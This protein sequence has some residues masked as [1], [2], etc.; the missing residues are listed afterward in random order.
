MLKPRALRPGDRVAVVAPASPF[1]REDFDAG[2][3]ELRR[4][5]FDPAFDDCVFDRSGYVA[6]EPGVRARA[7]MDAWRDPLVGGIIGARGGYGSVHLLPL[8]DPAEL[9]RSPKVFVG[10]SDLTSILAFL[11]TGCG[12]ACFHGPSVAG[13]LGGGAGGYDAASLLAAVTRAEPM[14]DIAAPGLETIRAGEASGPIHGGTLTQIV[15]SLGTPFAFAPPERFVLLVDE[16][17]ERP[18]RLDRMLTQLR[19]SGVLGRASAIVFAELM[20]C[21][22]PGGSPTARAVVGEVLRDFPGPVLFGVPT[23]HT[24]GPSVTI[25]LGVRARVIGG[26]EPRLVIEEA[27]VE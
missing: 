16:V 3:A 20:E 15:A 14:G 17:N 9:R 22:E 26:R 4:L 23:G 2:I 12:I 21:D 11:S 6:G 1:K 5:G 8:I 27:A 10:Y 24:A 13:R 18:Y 19:L 25:P 7:L